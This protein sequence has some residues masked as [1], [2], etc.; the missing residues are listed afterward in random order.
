[1][2]FN[3]TTGEL[4]MDSGFTRTTKLLVQDV[5]RGV[6][7][8]K[9]G[10]TLREI[11]LFGFGQGGMLGLLAARELG[12]SPSSSSSPGRGT[13]ELAGVISI[14]AA[15]PLSGSTVKGGNRTPVLLVAGRESR[16]VSDSAVR[17]TKDVFE[18]TEV[19]R[20]SRKNDGMPQNK[21]EMLPIMRFFAR[22]LRSWQGVPAGSVEIS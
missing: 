8:D 9:C 20:Y 19:E 4:D 1:M 18:F 22:R 14:G 12:S 13:G 5:I 2:T 3:S 7:V 15:Y 17:R 16:A 10:Y 21:D 11:M 6:L